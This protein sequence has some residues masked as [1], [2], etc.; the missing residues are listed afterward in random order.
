VRQ[1]TLALI[2]ENCNGSRGTLDGQN[3]FV[4]NSECGGSA[5]MCIRRVGNPLLSALCSLREAERPQSVR[6][7]NFLLSRCA[8]EGY[9]APHHAR[10]KEGASATWSGLEHNGS[11][12]P[13]PGSPAQTWKMISEKGR[14]AVTGESASEAYRKS[15]LLP[16][17]PDG[18]CIAR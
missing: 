11:V 12:I 1:P 3:A 10:F 16:E 9:P 7:H 13:R 8:T 17:G 5:S 15:T 6:P 14:E 4:D 18:E 2:V